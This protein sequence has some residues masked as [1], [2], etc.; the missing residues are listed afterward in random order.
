MADDR[1]QQLGHVGFAFD[2]IGIGDH[3]VW[4][5][6]E[7]DGVGGDDRAHGQCALRHQNLGALRNDLRRLGLRCRSTR[8]HAPCNQCRTDRNDQ[9]ADQQNQLLP[10]HGLQG[11]LLVRLQ[12]ATDDYGFGA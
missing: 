7:P 3:L 4:P 12:D 8:E 2:E 11:P 10:I 6:L 9:R 5:H 1:S